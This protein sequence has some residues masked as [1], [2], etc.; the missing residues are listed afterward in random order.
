MRDNNSGKIVKELTGK[1]PLYNLDPVLTFDYM[2]ECDKIPC[3][4]PNEKYL[5]LYAYSGR[6]SDEEADWISVYAKKKGLKVYAIG[7]VQR[8]ADKFIDCSPFEVLAYFKNAEEIITDT[9]HGSIFS[10]ITH[11]PFV[12]LVRKSVGTSYGNEEKLM[13]LLNR[14]GLS[15]RATF[16]V[17]NSSEIMNQRINYGK[18]D[19]FLSS[20]REK[21]KKYLSKNLL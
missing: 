21:A 1:E 9:F 14:L 4:N 2:N 20:E 3:I 7:G 15:E 5:I 12:T 10:I 16:S 18:V 8:G 19:S 6:I 11:R 17:E 13:D